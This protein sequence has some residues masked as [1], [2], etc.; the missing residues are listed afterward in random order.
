MQGASDLPVAEIVL[1]DRTCSFS[2]HTVPGDAAFRGE[3]GEDGRQI[4]G[5]FTQRVQV[6][7]MRLERADDEEEAADSREEVSEV[8]D[9]PPDGVTRREVMVGADGWLCKASLRCRSGPI[10]GTGRPGV[11][12]RS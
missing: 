12:S 10:A 6:F 7:P 9:A 11:L 1:E 3:V 5:E 2:L 4:I 8:G